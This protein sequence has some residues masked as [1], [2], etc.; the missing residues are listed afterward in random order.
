MGRAPVTPE[1]NGNP[2]RLVATPEAGVPRAGVTNV[3]ELDRTVFPVPVLLVTPV[4]PLATGR[5]PVTPV[6]IGNPVRLVATPEE[7]VPRAGV[8][9]V[10][11]VAKHT[12]PDPVSSEITPLSCNEVVAANWDSGSD[13]S[14][15][16]SIWVCIAEVTPLT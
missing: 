5:V 15:F 13:F 2:V 14:P 11:E 3:G 4:P 12:A 1:V 7:G 10:G 8:T 9:N 6:V 16:R